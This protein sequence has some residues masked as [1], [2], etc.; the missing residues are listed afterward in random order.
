[1]TEETPALT[2]INQPLPIP[3]LNVAAM[4]LQDHS[5]AQERAAFEEILSKERI[6]WGVNFIALL[7]EGWYWRDAA[8]IVWASL[9]R[10]L[11]VPATKGELAALL[12]ITP[13]ALSQRTTKNPAIQKRALTFTLRMLHDDIGS[14]VEALVISAS[15]PSYKHAPDRKL[16]LEIAG[17]YTPRQQIDLANT[18]ATKDDHQF[19]EADLERLAGLEGGK[20][21]G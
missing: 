15:D 1:M 13:Q 21:G 5:H 17:L 12:G 7:D 19:D 8:Y 11:R 10:A 2:P 4:P 20:D 14:V 18:T 9:P 16:A 3:G 6:A